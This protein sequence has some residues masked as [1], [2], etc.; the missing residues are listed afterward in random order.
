MS[1]LKTKMRLDVR[2]N[3]NGHCAGFRCDRYLKRS[4]FHVDHI[5]P[6]CEGGTNNAEN[7]QALCISCHMKKT[8]HENRKRML[9]SIR[10][11]KA[12][13]LA[14]GLKSAWIKSDATFEI[15]KQAFSYK[16]PIGKS[17]RI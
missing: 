10:L 12:E 11:S 13:K 2:K 6:R 9:G 1:L 4:E 7:L 8:K 3:Q 15:K 5:V 17:Y 14:L 16:K